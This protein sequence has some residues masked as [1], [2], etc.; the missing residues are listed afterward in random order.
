[1]KVVVFGGNGYVGSSII[2][3]LVSLSSSSSI[4]LTDIISISRSGMPLNK[5]MIV[6]KD[7]EQQT[8]LSYHYIDKKSY[9]ERNIFLIT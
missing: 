6:L 4:K 9:K 3:Q 2:K 7:Y 5:S 1:M 8:P